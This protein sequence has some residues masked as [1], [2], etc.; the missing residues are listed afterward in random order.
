MYNLFAQREYDSR[1]CNI[2]GNYFQSENLVL[3]TDKQNS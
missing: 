2:S 3:H 1:K